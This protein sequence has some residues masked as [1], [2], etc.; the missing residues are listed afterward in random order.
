[1]S[2][3]E[4]VNLCKQF[5]AN[6]Q[7]IRAV[8]GLNLALAPGEL[9]ERAAAT[10]ESQSEQIRILTERI[11]SATADVGRTRDNDDLL[12]RTLLLA[13]RAA[14]AREDAKLCHARRAQPAHGGALRPA[15]IL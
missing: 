13:Q 8:D 9:L 3:L 11:D 6:G 5:A 14:D 12:Q 7:I 1:M 4:L 10:I 2:R 15:R